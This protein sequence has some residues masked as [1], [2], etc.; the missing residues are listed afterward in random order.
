M[1]D[2]ELDVQFYKQYISDAHKDIYGFR[3]VDTLSDDLVVLKTTANAL[4]EIIKKEETYVR[5]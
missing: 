5:F 3:P 4:S 1:T 2:Y